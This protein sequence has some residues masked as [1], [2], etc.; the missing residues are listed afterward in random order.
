MRG[1]RGVWR[2]VR[3]RF[4]TVARA[5]ETVFTRALRG[6]DAETIA[7]SLPAAWEVLRA[8]FRA[9]G[10]LLLRAESAEGV[11]ASHSPMRESKRHLFCNACALGG[12]LA[13]LRRIGDKCA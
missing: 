2:A 7:A 3:R 9:I 8:R 6:F 1:A 13:G 12:I 4:R 11:C 5:A 10:G